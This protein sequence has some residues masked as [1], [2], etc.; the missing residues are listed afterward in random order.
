VKLVLVRRDH[1]GRIRPCVMA[2][3]Q[4]VDSLKTWRG[5][6]ATVMSESGWANAR[7]FGVERAVQDT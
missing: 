6:R 5:E 4:A 3:L 1:L 7:G 2:G